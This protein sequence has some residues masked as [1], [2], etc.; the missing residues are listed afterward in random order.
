MGIQCVCYLLLQ[1][2]RDFAVLLV[3]L[4]KDDDVLYAWGGVREGSRRGGSLKKKKTHEKQKKRATPWMVKCKRG[5]K[6]AQKRGAEEHRNGDG[7]EKAEGGMS[8]HDK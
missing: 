4:G 2:R 7:K 3:R 5:R 1:R 6:A 8:G